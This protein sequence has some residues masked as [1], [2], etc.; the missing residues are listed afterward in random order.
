MGSAQPKMLCLHGNRSNMMVTEMQME[1]LGVAAVASCSY[2]DGPH[3]SDTYDKDLEYGRTWWVEGAELKPAL[4]EV[5]EYAKKHGPFDGVFGFSMGA[6]VV[7]L[8]SDPAV[9]KS[10]GHEGGPLWRFALLACGTDRLLSMEPALTTPIAMPSLHIHGAKDPI[11]ADAQRLLKAWDRPKLLVHPYEHALP[12][13][14]AFA[15]AELLEK[16]TD[17]VKAPSY[18]AVA[19]E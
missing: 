2:I 18:E 11:L 8:L 10:L 16:V 9:L 19:A 12:M 1:V 13:Q 6:S 15:H 4:M 5:I 7:T 3:K 17:F 14:L